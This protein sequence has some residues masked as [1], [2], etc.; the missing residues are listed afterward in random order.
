MEVLVCDD[1]FDIGK[2][3]IGCSLGLS[4]HVLG[5][6]DIEALV[7]HRTHIEV[8]HSNN[9][10]AIQIQFQAIAR[11]IPADRMNQRIHGMA[12]FG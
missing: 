5:I 11:L 4:E 7:L 10:E 6:K 12:G 8:A 1:A 9:H 3:G 2:I